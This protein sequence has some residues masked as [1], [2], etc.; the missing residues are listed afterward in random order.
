MTLDTSPNLYR[1]APMQEGMLFHYLQ[2]AHSG[3]DIE[4][5]VCSLPEPVDSDAMRAACQ[6]I[7]DRH[8]VFRT[9]FEWEKQAQPM[10]KI[11]AH[12]EV[13][14]EISDLSSLAPDAQRE[15]LEQYLEEDRT[16]GFDLQ[17][18]PI[19]R[20][21]LFKQ[22]PSD[23]TLVWTFHH[24]LMDG[25]SFPIV[26]AE[27][28]DCYEARRTGSKWQ[29]SAPRP[30]REY[31]RWMDTQ[32]P[33]RAEGFWREALKGFALA[34][35]VPALMG[36]GEG[37]G[38]GEVE[39]S[40]TADATERLRKLAA[41]E[42]FTLNAVLQGAWAL[43]LGRYSVSSDVVFG[44]TRAC[45][46]FS[47]DAGAMVGTFINTLPMRVRIPD[48]DR[49][50]EWLRGIRA[51]N[52]AVREY[53]HTPLAAIQTWSEVPRN[54]PLFESI[55][56]FD[57]YLLNS[58]MQS[59]GGKWAV[60][61]VQLRERTNFPLTLYGYGE[62]GLILK[63]AFERQRFSAASIRRMLAHLQTILEAMASGVNCFLW[64]LPILTA[65]EQTQLLDE[66]NRTQTNYPRDRRIH[67]LVEDQVKRTPENVALSI[68]GQKMTYR[69]LN[70]R[71][72]RLAH[73][74]QT[75]GAGPGALVA[76]FVE[77]SLEM[78]VGLLAI[79]KTGAAYL[80]LDPIYP[81]E[82]LAFMLEDSGA[83]VLVTQESLLESVTQ[84]QGNVVCVDTEWPQISLEDA[85]DPDGGGAPEDCAYTI[86]TSGSTGT[87]KGVQISHRNVV[88]LLH[89]FL[90]GLSVTSADVLIAVTT[91]SFD[92]A[93][94]EI[95]MPLLCGARV[96]IASREVAMDGAELASEI[97]RSG[98]TLMQATPSTWQM[99]L[100][101]GWEGNP[102]LTVLCG[103][104]AFPAGLIQ[105]LREKVKTVWNVY[106]PTET[107]IWSS[108]Y[109]LQPGDDRV[110]IGRPVANT[111][112][113]VLDEHRQL[114]P[115]G[116]PGELYIGGDGVAIGYW[117]R[118]ELNAEKFVPN[119]FDSSGGSRLYRTGDRV[120]YRADGNLEILG[121]FDQQVKLRGFRI[122]LGEITQVLVR[123][124]QVK[125]AVVILREDRPGDKRLVGYVVSHSGDAPEV[126]HLKAHLKAKLPD[127]MV[128]SQ[129]VFL[130]AMPYL[131]N[132]K[133]N[134]HALPAPERVEALQNEEMVA[135]RD[136]IEEHL[137][138]IWQKLL[139][140]RNIGIR[141]NFFDLGGHSLLLTR[142]IG[143]IQKKFGKRLSIATMFDSP[144]IEDQAA[145]LRGEKNFSSICRVIPLKPQGT[146][147]PIVCLGASPLFLPLARRL[148]RERPFYGLDLTELQKINLPSHK[149]EDIAAYVIEA[150]REFQPE[151]PYYIGGFCMWGVLA[152]EAS[153]QLLA[154]GHDVAL[155][156]MI[157]TPNSAYDRGLSGLA[158]IQAKTEK[159]LF[160]LTNLIKASPAEMI[161]YSKE[162]YQNARNKLV[163][164][165]ERLSFKSGRDKVDIRLMDLDP[166]LF[167]AASTYEP[168]PYPGRVV[169]VQSAERPPGQHWQLANQWRGTI[170]GQLIAHR[171]PGGH[172]GMFKVPHVDT[173]AA[174]L[175]D[176]FEEAARRP[177]AESDG[178]SVR[179]EA[180]SIERY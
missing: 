107:T 54:T 167:Y 84:F 90:H 141:E 2:S 145:V 27:L 51:A 109:V 133:V 82:R 29:S 9:G 121:R 136:P 64:E 178:D 73:Y 77:R 174:K 118:P 19:T 160:H 26:L 49:L 8:D 30:F 155:L 47:P 11:H 122:E 98:A 116:V 71:A 165:R 129:F 69:E 114:A 67:T 25:R 172:V 66:W 103:G 37:A 171:V 102:R 110:S 180:Q 35:R 34:T 106:G 63:L 135:P 23:Y 156:I 169:V 161:H 38:R 91:L 150:V 33:S 142:L 81:K 100:D 50:Y 104:E 1:L 163:R 105:P 115:M 149:L 130:E 36:A 22:G 65:S 6:A 127:Y 48:E 20:F 139:N 85:R 147:P 80:P 179:L 79:L 99:L 43:L 94:L 56:V 16:G 131:A 120:R 117:N 13:P 134:R 72:N 89:S 93:G 70:L 128:P 158:R 45:R 153:R 123:H 14:F 125:E 176:S 144:T 146:L 88:N 41:A 53:E 175:K 96:V 28:F 137:L 40:L 101:S 52:V 154:Q 157:D 140:R 159:T 55:I 152:Y 5:L 7:V 59:L 57:N 32:D 3:V 83:S 112:F 86:Y 166:I 46:S 78:V 74:L 143:Q 44:A 132:G 12:A 173:L 10:Q 148:G 62:T 92:I 177:A 138:A 39:I 124:P 42:G 60:R 108:T 4:Q 18:P 97:G 61:N 170:S 164:F 87:P 168:R 31:I 76:I 119:L 113:Y 68:G 75:R 15:H 151:G 111:Q 17:C 24:V 126:G 58:R 95:W 162:R 21:S